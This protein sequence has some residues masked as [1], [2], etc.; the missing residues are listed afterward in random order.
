[1]TR[2][3]QLAHL[4]ML[5]TSNVFKA[6][7]LFR[8]GK[9]GDP[10]NHALVDVKNSTEAIDHYLGFNPVRKVNFTKAK[11]SLRGKGEQLYILNEVLNRAVS[12]QEVVLYATAASDKSSYMAPLKLLNRYYRVTHPVVSHSTNPYKGD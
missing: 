6:R 5:L 2:D 8:K 1:M 3:P 10:F 11:E 4:A 12:F 9:L 7:Q